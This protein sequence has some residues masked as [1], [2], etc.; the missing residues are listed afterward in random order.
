MGDLSG[1]SSASGGASNTGW[2]SSMGSALVP[3]TPSIHP[4]YPCGEVYSHIW[5]FER[6]LAIPEDTP[7]HDYGGMLEVQLFTSSYSGV[8]RGPRGFVVLR[9][10]LGLELSFSSPFQAPEP[11]QSQV[12]VVPLEESRG[13]FREPEG[14]AATREDLEEVLAQGPSL[15]V[16]GD[17]WVYGAQGYGQE[18]VYLRRASLYGPK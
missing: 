2:I 3:D 5:H 10:S 9:S 7:D 16:R 4:R 13:W 11:G 18:V 6:P 12:F 14:V 8:D 1:D 17:M 15:L